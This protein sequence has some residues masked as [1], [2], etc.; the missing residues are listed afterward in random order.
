MKLVENLLVLAAFVAL[1]V[2]GMIVV[3]VGGFLA[4]DFARG[5]LEDDGYIAAARL[6]QPLGVASFFAF[7][8]VFT[9]WLAKDSARKLHDWMMGNRTSQ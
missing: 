9:P 3:A 5:L 6:A 7:Y 2:L 8:L 4:G 1:A